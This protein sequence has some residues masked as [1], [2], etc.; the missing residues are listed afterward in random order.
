[1]PVEL[2]KNADGSYTLSQ[3]NFDYYNPGYDPI[4]GTFVDICGELTLQG[5]PTNV[6]GIAWIGSG[7]YD[8]DTG[9]LSFS[10]SDQTYNPDYVVDMVFEKQ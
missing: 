8:P 2:T 5:T 9:N 7:S 6:F 4:P 10:V 1:M 3:M